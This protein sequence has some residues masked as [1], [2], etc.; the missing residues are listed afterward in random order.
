L[1]IYIVGNASGATKLFGAAGAT[2]V[3]NQDRRIEIRKSDKKYTGRDGR[4]VL[5]NDILIRPSHLHPYVLVV[6]L[7]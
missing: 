6:W 7:Y 2:N 5:K 3:C 4:V 1:D